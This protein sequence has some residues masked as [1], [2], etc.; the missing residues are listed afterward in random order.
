MRYLVTARL[1]PGQE[2][3]L[4]EALADGTLGYVSE[5]FIRLVLGYRAG[6]ARQDGAWRMQFFV[7]GD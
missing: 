4:Y 5:D 6:F 7:A 2:S 3:P 1:K